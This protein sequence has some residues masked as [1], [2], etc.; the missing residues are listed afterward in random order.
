MKSSFIKCIG[1]FFK[2]EIRK[3]DTKSDELSSDIEGFK[4]K[5]ATYFE[6]KDHVL[7]GQN[8]PIF[9][10]RLEDEEKD[11]EAR[12]VYEKKRYVSKIFFF[13]ICTL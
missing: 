9:I 8:T 11:T 7:F 1:F 4:V 6:E 5:Y 12:I 10:G 2:G 3:R 13:S